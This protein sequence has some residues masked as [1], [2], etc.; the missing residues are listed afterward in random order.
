M[1]R[2]GTTYLRKVL[3]LRVHVG[4]C[5]TQID[6][7]IVQE[8]GDQSR[9]IWRLGIMNS[10]GIVE[11][12]LTVRLHGILAKVELTPGNLTKCD[13]GKAANL[14]QR[15]EVVGLN[16]ERF[17]GAVRN[18]SVLHGAFARFFGEN[19][20]L[21]L[22]YGERKGESRLSCSCL[23]LSR[24]SAA[25]DE[26]VPFEAG[27]DPL[28]QLAKFRK[29]GLVHTPENKVSYLKTIKEANND[30]SNEEIVIYEAFPGSFRPGD[31]VEVQG[32]LIALANKHG[33][34]KTTFQLSA[35]NLID[36][37]FSK[38]AE[39]SRAKVVIPTPAPV[40]LKRKLWH[41]AEDKEVVRARRQLRE[42]ALEDQETEK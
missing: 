32:S 13:A 30:G 15:I 4:V 33:K 5:V 40:V 25:G 23:F 39:R 7:I 42:L 26:E 16:S 19:R 17:E 11:N 8:T 41:E 35:L 22:N 12:E 1:V 24:I 2:S 38:A 34:V 20:M 28:G 6:N 29:C 36:A 18:I 3:H 31:I 10:D 37:S 9:K 14:C 21:P 27:V